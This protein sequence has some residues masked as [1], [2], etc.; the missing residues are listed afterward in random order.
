[1]SVRLSPAGAARLAGVGRTT[2][3]EAIGSGALR[4]LK[5]GKR[6]LILIVSLRD[7]LETAQQAADLAAQRRGLAPDALASEG[8]VHARAGRIGKGW[9]VSPQAD[10]NPYGDGG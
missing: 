3:Y 8:R 10:R 5:I 7:W 1:M 9:A 2:I 6:R 4:S